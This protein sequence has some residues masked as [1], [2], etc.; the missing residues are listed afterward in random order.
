MNNSPLGDFNQQVQVIEE[1]HLVQT[2]LVSVLLLVGDILQ[3]T[4]WSNAICY[5]F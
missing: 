5:Y 3:R 4:P 2:Q 1:Y